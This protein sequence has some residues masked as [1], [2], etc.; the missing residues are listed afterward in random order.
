MSLSS[1]KHTKRGETPYVSFIY[2]ADDSAAEWGSRL[3]VYP[4]AYRS[5]AAWS[6]VFKTAD[7]ECVFV[8]HD[9]AFRG[10]AQP[11]GKRCVVR[12]G[13][14][15]AA[16]T[17]L[18][19]VFDGL[20]EEKKY[21]GGLF[22]VSL[23]DRRADMLGS[24][25]AHDLEPVGAVSR[26]PHD[27]E[28]WLD[29]VTATDFVGTADAL[30]AVAA[31][32]GTYYPQTSGYPDKYYRVATCYNQ[33]A[34]TM[35]VKFTEDV[36]DRAA[37][38]VKRT[39]LTY[40]GNPGTVVDRILTGT[41]GL[42]LAAGELDTTIFSTSRAALGGVTISHTFS[43]GVLPKK[44]IGQHLQQICLE[45][46]ADFFVTTEGLYA[47][48][49]YYPPMINTAAIGSYGTNEYTDFEVS[50]ELGDLWNAVAYD[51]SRVEEYRQLPEN[52]Q[53]YGTE[54]GNSIT[55]YGKRR[56][57]KIDAEWIDNR[58]SARTMAQRFLLF[59]GTV[60]DQ[61]SF[62]VPLYGIEERVGSLAKVYNED[63]EDWGGGNYCLVTGVNPEL[64][65]DR[66]SIE[67]VDVDALS[68]SGR[69]WFFLAP[70]SD[71]GDEY[72]T[73]S[74]TAADCGCIF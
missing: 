53:Q 51:L 13:F 70:A 55:A 6:G 52:R 23:V 65:D 38:L 71:S 61:V 8:N 68:S 40:S 2:D 43:G 67:A 54:D 17:D 58:L 64:E 59:R 57:K 33:G 60:A 42:G 30:L 37:Y 12:A 48:A 69:N 73:F 16:G 72:G 49:A 3:E 32:A 18:G 9:R 22:R 25:F 19:T 1:R 36:M 56:E 24:Y 47:Y 44:T 31:G 63:E 29:G 7:M 35:V 50:G 27:D 62:R 4:N 11:E 28:C 21:G 34:G 46:N 39:D 45:T 15:G 5:I 14:A 20:I 74:A 66:V 10:L 26:W 41:N